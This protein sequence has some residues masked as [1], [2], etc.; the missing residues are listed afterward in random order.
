MQ[1]RMES[2][3]S[4]SRTASSSW[5][6]SGRARLSSV[7]L[8]LSLIVVA[9][10]VGWLPTEAQS[11]APSKESQGTSAQAY[12]LANGPHKIQEAVI[13]LR[14]GRRDKD[15]AVRV[16]YPTAGGPFPV[17]VFSAG[18]GGGND[19]FAP[20]S[21]FLASHGY[22]VMHNSSARGKPGPEAWKNRVLD[23]ILV[24][25][26]LEEIERREPELKGKI[27]HERIGVMGH[28]LG[29]YTTQLVGGATVDWPGQPAEQSFADNHVKAIIQYSGQG[30]DQQG[31]TRKS[32]NNMKLPMMTMTGSKDR[33]ARRQGPDW[34]KEPFDYS[35]PGDK[36]H[37]FIEGAHHGS[38]SGRF[39]R[40]DE[41]KIILDYIKSAT[42]AFWDAYLKQDK[43]AKAY[44]QSDALE[45]YS[46]YKVKLSRK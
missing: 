19:T 44:L 27:N 13:N 28:S 38:F 3:T 7:F 10:A 21:T 46:N 23:V 1:R 15:V 32:W 42:I 31:L 5:L 25:N 39:A 35:P 43:T 6:F 30:T 17:I 14:D 20:I 16:R 24:L 26:S 37:V 8:A 2:R 18:A 22:V 9:E 29:A 11:V 36:Y 40:A 41:Q 34:K 33:G 4:G 12:K 45:A